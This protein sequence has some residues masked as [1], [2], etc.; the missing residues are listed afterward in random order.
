MAGGFQQVR[1]LKSFR[2]K[3]INEIPFQMQI[4]STSIE[5]NYTNMKNKLAVIKTSD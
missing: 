1:L 3:A 5:L 2:K 4:K